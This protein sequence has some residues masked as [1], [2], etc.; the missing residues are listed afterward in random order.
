MAED[1]RPNHPAPYDPARA[2][3]VPVDPAPVDP[4]S[5]DPEQ[6]RQFEQFQQFQQFMRFQEA[7]GQ[8]QLPPAGPPPKKKPTWQKI[9]FSK[10]FRKLVVYALVIIGV[11][12]A[13]NHYFGSPPDDNTVQGGAGPGSKND[14]GRAPGKPNEVVDALY[15]SISLGQPQVACYMFTKDAEAAF[16]RNFEAADCTAA[17]A[18]LQSQVAALTGRPRIDTQGKQL[19]EVDSCTLR[20]KPGTTSLG[21]FTFTPFGDAWIISGHQTKECST[22]TTTTTTAPPT[23]TTSR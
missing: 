22:A 13:Y 11:I 18:K 9:L 1:E 2:N 3:P 19:V 6:R 12:W 21:T 4:T 8:G 14:P 20:V 7:Q 5:A 10:G 17:V 16:A 15:R 23:T